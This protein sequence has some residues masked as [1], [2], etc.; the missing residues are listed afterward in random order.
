MTLE[1]WAKWREHA[2][3][4][5]MRFAAAPEYQVFPSEG[6]ALKP[7][8]AA[9]RASAVT[10][11]LIRSVDAELVV[12][13]ILTVAATL[14]AEL[15]DRPWATLVPHVLPMGEPGFPVYA[16]G[17]VYPRTAF[18]ARLWRV[19][20][21][22]LMRGEQQ[23]RAELN[24]TR[25]RV[26]LPPLDHVHG[27]T[28]RKLALVATLPQLEY[29]RQVSEPWLRV[30][31]PL[32]WEQP[33]GEVEPP[34]GD[35]P[36]VLV[37]PS[38]SQDPEHRLLRATLEGLAGEPVRVLATTNRRP[39]ERPIDVPANARLV[40][41]VSYARTMPH[42]AAVVCHAGH[43]TVVRALACGTPVVACPHAGDMA[44]NA[45]RLRWAGLGVSL[46]RRFHT[47]RGVRLAVRRLLADPGY[48]QR[49]GEV[50]D[51]CATHDGAA[52]AADELSS[53]M[54]R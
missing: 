25:A 10:R 53:V 30:P 27:G 34:P 18:G 23:G 36:L 19:S 41:W 6:Q 21:P 26:G 44:E 11:A 7:Y 38:T 15:E 49:A 16:V 4:E 32:L 29:P 33:F 24:E 39:P 52:A 35:E 31:G 50:R 22:L 14:A 20:R 2:E 1:T 13:D 51:W 8:A 28:S 54:C 42:C 46:P 3:R 45:A 43:G 5:G 47:P 17:A 9:V 12:A 37:A 48:A 40:D